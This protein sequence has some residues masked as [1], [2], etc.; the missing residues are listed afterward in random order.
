M[1]QK[2]KLTSV[3]QKFLAQQ[4]KREQIYLYVCALGILVAV[5]I[6]G[7]MS[8]WGHFDSTRFVLAIMILLNARS[9][10]KQYKNIQ[11]LKKLSLP[12]A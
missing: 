2:D 6:I 11:L 1:M 3:E 4:L 8:I 5:A 12:L 7:Y 10:L 9:N